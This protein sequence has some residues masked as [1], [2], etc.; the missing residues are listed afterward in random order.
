[1]QSR[2]LY[3]TKIGR[4]GISQNGDSITEIC[5]SPS[6]SSLTKETPLL[7]QTAEELFS[8]LDGK[9]KAFSVALSPQGTPF[10]QR[11][12][13]ALCDI[14]YGQTRSYGDI[15]RAIGNP[16]AARAVGMAN[17]NNPILIMIPCHRVI[18]ANGT[19]VGYGA[20]LDTKQYL[21]ELE[22]AQYQK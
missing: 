7:R 21:L 20:G 12:W 18:G 15:A 9:R 17:H 4:I 8:Y 5:L 22:G 10:Q 16:N 6:W 1:M 13:R 14:P 2:Y 19:L 11:V 3:Q